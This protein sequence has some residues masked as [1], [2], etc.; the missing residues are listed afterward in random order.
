MSA[1][2]IDTNIFLEV[3]ARPG[4][5]SDRCLAL[6]DS[7]K[8]LWTTL[9]VLAEVEW[10]L[11][12]GYELPKDH[13]VVCIKRILTLP[14]LDIEKKETLLDA[15]PLYGKSNADWIDCVNAVLCREAES[16]QVCSYDKHYDRFNWIKRIE[17]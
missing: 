6:L 12:S 7:N 9:L 8:S 14:S 13:I 11:R 3:L 5:K 10:V 16:K 1:I 17:P 2:F 4:E 15:L